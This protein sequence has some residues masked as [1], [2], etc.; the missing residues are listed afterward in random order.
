MT[1][2]EVLCLVIAIQL[3]IL[4]VLFLFGKRWDEIAC[5]VVIAKI[6][7]VANNIAEAENNRLE[8]KGE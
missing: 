1:T 3:A 4:I 5:Q 8:E 7:K 2:L 6:T